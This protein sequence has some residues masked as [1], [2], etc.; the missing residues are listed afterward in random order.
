MLKGDSSRISE[1]KSFVS[2]K[3]GNEATTD[4]N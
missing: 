4:K 2:S 1:R 3:Y